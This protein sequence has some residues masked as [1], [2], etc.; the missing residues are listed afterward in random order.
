MWW[1]RVVQEL[2]DATKVR[3]YRDDVGLVYADELT[4]R[5]W[6]RN[7][8]LIRWRGIPYGWDGKIPSWWA[9]IAC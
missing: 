7:C 9:R 4:G 8:L 5:L 6:G 2:D 3:E 1:P